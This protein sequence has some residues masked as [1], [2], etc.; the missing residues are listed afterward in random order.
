MTAHTERLRLGYA[1]AQ[2]FDV[3]A[4]V[5][6]YP[7]FMSWVVDAR[8]RRRPDHTFLVDITIAA[9]P[10][11]RRFTTTGVLDRPHRIEVTSN[12]PIFKHYVQRWT[13]EPTAEGATIAECHVEFR[14]RSHLLHSLMAAAFPR[15]AAAIISAFKNRA[16]RLYSTRPALQGDAGT[17]LLQKS[18]RSDRTKEIRQE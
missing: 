5:E 6:R 7:E 12:D 10:L 1:P 4:D 2:V 9:G 3:V 15:Q 11:R 18:P 17:I 16:D 14:L 13:F 8:M